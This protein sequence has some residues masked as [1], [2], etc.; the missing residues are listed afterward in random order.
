MAKLQIE[1]QG[2]VTGDGKPEFKVTPIDIELPDEAADLLEKAFRIADTL[3]AEPGDGEFDQ[4]FKAK[5]P[6]KVNLFIAK[7]DTLIPVQ[8]KA[9]VRIKRDPVDGPDKAA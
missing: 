1:I 5:I 6:V 4:K 2:D 7:I 8:G 3:D 9:T